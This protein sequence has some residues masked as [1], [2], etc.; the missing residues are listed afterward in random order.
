MGSIRARGRLLTC[1]HPWMGSSGPENLQLPWWID[2]KSAVAGDIEKKKSFARY[3]IFVSTG[4]YIHH[5]TTI[6]VDNAFATSFT[7]CSSP[8]RGWLS[9]KLGDLPQGKLER[10][11]EQSQINIR[12]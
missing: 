11:P 7:L 9:Q 2:L 10:F 5:N 4:G 12:K 8:S 3:R 6:A 1:Q